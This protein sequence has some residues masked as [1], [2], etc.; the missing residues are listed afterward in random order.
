MIVFVEGTIVSHKPNAVVVAVGGIGYEV[1]VPLRTMASLIVGSSFRLH[2]YHKI[3]E[4]TNSLYGFLSSEEVDIFTT[5]ISISGIGAKTALQMLEF[6]ADHISKAIETEDI[7]SLTKIPGL[8]KKTASRLI[9]ELK[10]KI[11]RADTSTASASSPY[12]SV[13]DILKSLGF[14]PALV[15]QCFAKVPESMQTESDE[16]LV[17]WGLQQ[18]SR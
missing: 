3:S 10:G 13:V 15:E 6:P 14:A 16:T 18:L 2:T 11:V 7:D 9:L 17:K 12:Q 1:F 4:D 8:G 5:L